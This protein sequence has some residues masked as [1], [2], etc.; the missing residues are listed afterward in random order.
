VT[1]QSRQQRPLSK[2]FPEIIAARQEHFP[3]GV[4]LNGVILGLDRRVQ[5]A[6]DSALDVTRSS[7][8]ASVATANELDRKHSQLGPIDPQLVTPTGAVPTKAILQDFER[9]AQECG[10]DPGKLSAWLP[11]LQQYY[12]GMLEFC[13]SA[14]DLARELV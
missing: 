2:Y 8:F 3:G 12:P 5:E 4:V 9:A 14:E 11:T 10:G 13:R 6:V 1:L 7:E